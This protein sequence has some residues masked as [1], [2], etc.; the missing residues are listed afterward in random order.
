[1]RAWFRGG[2]GRILSGGLERGAN[3]VNGGGGWC[4]T[5]GGWGWSMWIKELESQLIEKGFKHE[6]TATL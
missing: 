4:L 1:M 5:W 2:V 3:G 6:G